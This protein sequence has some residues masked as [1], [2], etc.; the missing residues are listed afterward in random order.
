MTFAG[1][2][3]LVMGVPCEPTSVSEV[4]AAVSISRGVLSANGVAFASYHAETEM[5]R[6]LHSEKWWHAFRIETIHEHAQASD[7]AT[8]FARRLMSPNRD[9]D[10]LGRPE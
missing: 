4:L 2:C 1:P 5:W 6:A 8:G 9:S 3:R 7:D 10:S